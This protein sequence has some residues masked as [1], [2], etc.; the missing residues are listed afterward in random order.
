MVPAQYTLQGF[1]PHVQ[2]SQPLAPT[3]I[4]Q[5]SQRPQSPKK[6]DRMGFDRAGRLIHRCMSPL[7]CGYIGGLRSQEHLQ[8]ENNGKEGTQEES[9]VV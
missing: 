6:R 2:K 3:E 8:N 9:Q 7:T 1:S 5:L 4:K